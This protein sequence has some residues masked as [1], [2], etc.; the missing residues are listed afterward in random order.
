MWRKAWWKRLS[1]EWSHAF[2]GLS[3]AFIICG[4]SM[5]TKHWIHKTHTHK[6][7][8]AHLSYKLTNL[9][10]YCKHE[11]SIR[12]TTNEIFWHTLCCSQLVTCSTSLEIREYMQ[13]VNDTWSR[14]TKIHENRKIQDIKDTPR[15]QDELP[16]SNAR[17]DCVAR[18]ERKYK[19]KKAQRTEMTSAERNIVAKSSTFWRWNSAH[20]IHRNMIQ[21][22]TR[23]H[24]KVRCQAQVSGSSMGNPPN[25]GTSNT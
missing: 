10:R 21:T 4:I 6:Q 15:A 5:S 22:T 11:Q 18:D 16:Y 1:L 13:G 7:Q 23:R 8:H 20:L 24:S 12:A 3:W 19:L 2:L 14:N 25:V 9:S 17:S